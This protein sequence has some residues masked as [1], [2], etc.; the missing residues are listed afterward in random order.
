MLFIYTCYKQKLELI[1]LHFKLT[2]FWRCFFPFFLLLLLLSAAY[3]WYLFY[4]P[5]LLFFSCSVFRSLA[6]SLS[7]SLALNL[8]SQK[9]TCAASHDYVGNIWPVAK[10]RF[11][12]KISCA[13]DFYQKEISKRA[14]EFIINIFVIGSA[15]LSTSRRMRINVCIQYMIVNKNV[16]I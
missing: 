14:V 11:T 12:I 5:F 4:F 6:R 8:S 1:Y 2:G 13:S 9:P 16:A 15:Y 3:L 7:H 10:F